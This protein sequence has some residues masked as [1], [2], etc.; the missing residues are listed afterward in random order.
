MDQLQE[1][2]SERRAHHEEQE[3]A[4]PPG[5][6]NSMKEKKITVA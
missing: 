6:L 5:E 2:E 1:Y 3:N 4:P